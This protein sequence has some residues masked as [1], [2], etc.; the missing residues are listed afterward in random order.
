[1]LHGHGLSTRPGSSRCFW[2][3]SN[4]AGATRRCPTRTPGVR[5]GR[6][7]RSSTK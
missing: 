6:I 1:V 4:P 7:P 5:S 3:K 2:L